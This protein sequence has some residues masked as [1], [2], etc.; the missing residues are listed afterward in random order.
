MV[1]H[2]FDSKTHFNTWLGQQENTDKDD[3]VCHQVYKQVADK[4]VA[5]K[6]IK[7]KIDAI[8]EAVPHS[9]YFICIEGS[10]NF[11]MDYKTPYVDYKGQRG[12]KPL[13]FHECREYILQ[14][15]YDHVILA[16][17]QET[18]DVINIAAWESFRM[19]S[20]TKNQDDAPYVI[21]YIDKDIT[22]NGRG[23]FINY[24]KLEEGV[25]WVGPKKQT[26][27]FWIQTLM[28]DAADNIKGLPEVS[29]EVRKKYGLRRC[30]VGEKGAH[31]LLEGVK[32][33]FELLDRVVEAYY[34]YY[35]DN[36]YQAL[37]DNCFFLYLRR[38]PDEMF[39][40]QYYFD[41]IGYDTKKRGVLDVKY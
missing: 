28:G 27:D 23:W 12:E 6:G 39:N 34:S 25:K 11:R 3:W 18:D 31:S 26:Y 4:T 24:N 17:G 8:L 38:E 2:K 5:F 32:D 29:Q 15:Y 1:K 41:S 21:A 7:D 33:K 37:Q 14:N 10:G 19:A 22:A 35:K 9:E 13:L 20:K 40:L 16:E 36:W 30:S